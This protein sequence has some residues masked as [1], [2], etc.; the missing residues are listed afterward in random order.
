MVYNF[1]S[2]KEIIKNGFIITPT[3]DH[4]S[5]YF[6]D[7]TLINQNLIISKSFFLLAVLFC[8]SADIML[9]IVFVESNIT[10][11]TFRQKITKS[12]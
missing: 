6:N 10:Y 2:I 9:D 11:I 1:L 5:C 3:L 8:P 12:K 7:N 4:I